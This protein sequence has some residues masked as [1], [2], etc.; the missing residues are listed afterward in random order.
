MDTVRSFSNLSIEGL[1][2]YLEN[3]Q[4]P[5]EDSQL[6]S[7]ARDEKFV[8]KSL[9]KS[10]FRAIVDPK[11]FDLVEKDIVTLLNKDDPS[12]E[13]SLRRNDITHIV[14]DKGGFFDRHQDYL[15]TTSNLVQE[16]TLLICVTPKDLLVGAASMNDCGGNTKLY[17]YGGKHSKTFDTT[18]PG[19]GLL[20]RKDLEHE[21]TQL[22][23][24]P[25]KHILTANLWATR[26]EFSDQVLLVTFPNDKVQHSAGKDTDTSTKII[27][28][29]ACQHSSY[30]IPVDLLT[31]MLQAHVEWVNRVASEEGNVVPKVVPYECRDFS[32]EEF[33]VV[34]KMLHHSYVNEQMVEQAKAC[35]DFYGPFRT[36]DILLQLSLEQTKEGGQDDV[37]INDPSSPA[38]K[39]KATEQGTK[40]SGDSDDCF[41]K[42]VI[43]CESEARMRA[44]ASVAAS[45]GEPYVPFKMLFVEGELKFFFEG[46]SPSLRDVSMMPIAVLAGDYDCIFSL[47]SMCNK[48]GSLDPIPFENINTEYNYWKAQLADKTALALRA[49]LKPGDL[50]TK[51]FDDETWEEEC[52]F[53]EEAYGLGL[54]V[55]LRPDD[56]ETIQSKLLQMLLYDTDFSLSDK[57]T[58]LPGVEADTS[59][60]I[61][62][63][64]PSFFHRDEQGKVVFSSD[65]AERTSD[66]LVSMNLE[67]RV[68]ACLQKKRFVLP[69]QSHTMENF[70]CNESVYGKLN[71]LW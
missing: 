59:G 8:D 4:Q 47:R 1:Q 24:L 66:F 12:Y 36:E 40:S 51:L 60:K 64:M 9:R 7:A 16:F 42:E 33:G 50:V 41:D 57:L 29:V 19:C 69:Q 31:G 63:N 21:G 67:N 26:K 54:K 5:F 22:T 23:S 27:Q 11:L 65:E 52:K 34:A 20:F 55:A 49:S 48:H 37:K 28:E 43:V 61:G 71:L 10:S 38:T 14:Y 3:C 58:S 70:F 46:C 35:L 18:T 6:Y 15:S 68:K 56:R 2:K 53:K 45:L 62:Q 17:S 44:V 32:H 25:T 13:Y 30:A 39:K